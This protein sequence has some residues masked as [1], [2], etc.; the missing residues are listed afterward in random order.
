[1]PDTDLAAGYLATAAEL[2]SNYSATESQTDLRKSIS[3]AYYAVFHGLACEAANV[4]I[5][6][7][8]E[9]RSN[10][11]WVEV[12]RGLEHGLCKDA[13]KKAKKIRFP[14]GIL[15][16]SISFVYL[17]DARQR[18]DYDP[19]FRCTVNDARFCLTIAQQ[20]I[21]ALSSVDDYDKR[22]FVTFVL[23]TSKGAQNARSIHKNGIVRH[24][25]LPK[26]EK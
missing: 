15:D 17:Q 12:Y 23:I 24:L 20:A 19:L 11:A 6:L 21:N 5:G 18:A 3:C 7:P 13:C 4:L 22:A 1:M 2:L 9:G 8:I 16:F 14:D 26:Q 25:E 10:R